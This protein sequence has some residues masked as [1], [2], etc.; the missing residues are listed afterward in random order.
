MRLL[1]A[2]FLSW[3]C[4]DI[5]GAL[6]SSTLADETPLRVG[7]A[8]V[9]ITPSDSYPMSGYYFERLST[10]VKDPLLAKALV[11]RQG[12]TAAAV[13]VC[14]II[15]VSADLTV[16][17]R[18]RAAEATGIPAEHILLSATHSHTG[19]D[20][21]KE[22]F[23][24]STGRPVPQGHNKRDPY[25]PRLIDAIVSAIGQAN[26]S[27]RLVT[28]TTGSARQ[29]TPV[30]FNRRFLMKD[31]KVRTW[32]NLSHP[33]VVHAAGPID[34]EIGLVRF[35]D[36]DAKSPL[37]VLSSFALHLD[38]VG[39][40]EYSADYPFYIDRTVKECLGHQVISVFGTGCCGN[41]NHVNPATPDRNKT[42]FIGTSLG[43]TICTA[44]PKLRP[45]DA[46][47]LQVRHAVVRAPL[48]RST[49]AQLAASKE[50]LK[51][52]TPDWA[53]EFFAHVDAYKR[54][55]LENLRSKMDP[56]EAMNLIGWGL[57]SSLAA[58]GDT[59]P[60]DVQV[61]TLGRDVAIV[62]LPGE[63]FVELGLAIKNASPFRTTLVIELSNQVETIYVP[64]RFAH[65]GGGYEV[66][67]STLEP[68]G[69]ELLAEAAI[70]LLAES[71][72]SLE[73][74]QA[75]K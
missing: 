65:V 47:G 36:A 15:A 33:D 39:G 49:P 73:S 37:A 59:L 61:I 9:D 38:T 25:V 11:F 18:K 34:P 52:I 74:S 22:L 35:D 29:E 72:A 66:L 4:A 55:V 12:E 45:V 32:M 67:N 23:A 43:K 5:S 53:P 27:L 26:D 71:A 70:R 57:C 17:V 30:S 14:D 8:T 56:E 20:Y 3:M 60:L 21:G 63:V 50:L 58:S 48:Q 75:A 46:P 54:I 24:I 44:L 19:P 51:G 16:A 40:T 41:I 7:V 31:G 10:G 64:T 6:A 13:V 68:G 28:V 42:D 69:G 2:F 62:A 1:R